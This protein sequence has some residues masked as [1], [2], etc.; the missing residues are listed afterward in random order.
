MD[1]S[2]ERLLEFY[3]QM[4]MIRAFEPLHAGSDMRRFIERIGVDRIRSHD[5]HDSDQD[6]GRRDQRRRTI[7]ANRIMFHGHNI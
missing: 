1:L 7:Q 3:R 2:R 6:E 4:R 5:L